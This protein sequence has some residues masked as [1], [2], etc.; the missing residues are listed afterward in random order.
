MPPIL[1]RQRQAVL[2][3]AA[4]HGLRNVRVF[5]SARRGEDRPDS[6]ID[7]LVEVDPGRT[8][9]DVI[10]FEQDVE[11]LLARPVDVVTEGGLSPYLQGRIL[12][13]AAAL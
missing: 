5:G 11:E 3:L 8:L 2:D 12:A 7:L 6:D 4:H 9:L 10:G 1:V 13:D